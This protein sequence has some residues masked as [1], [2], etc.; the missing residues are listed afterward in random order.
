MNTEWGYWFPDR[1]ET[2]EDAREWLA[3]SHASHE[4]I[5][6]AAGEHDWHRSDYWTDTEITVRSPD[7]VTKKFEVYV[8]MSPDFH[9]RELQPCA[10]RT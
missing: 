2:A 3:S 8:R 10:T 5:A 4:R 6:A 7:G 9:T 1:G